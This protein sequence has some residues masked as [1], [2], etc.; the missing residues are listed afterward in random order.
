MRKNLISFCVA[1][2]LFNACYSQKDSVHTLFNGSPHICIPLKYSYLQWDLGYT[3]F[4]FSNTSINGYSLDVI[5]LVF[6]ND[7]DIAVGFEGGGNRGGFGYSTVTTVI[8]YS[9]AYIRF[10]PMLFPEKLFNF[11]MPLKFAYSNIGVTDTNIYAAGYGRR[12]RRGGPGSTF[13][14]F[15]PGAEVFINMFHFLSV[16]G[17][18]NYRFAFSTPGYYPKSDYDNLSFSGTL[19]FKIYPHRKT[20][21][22]M[23]Y[24]APPQQRMN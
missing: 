6:N 15:T 14:S 7:L 2:S 12:G 8:S 13:F 3:N 1:F 22:Q 4:L 10:V 20:V 21:R 9:S 23:E 24:Y 11:S 18:V 16:G 19:R 5:G 17:G